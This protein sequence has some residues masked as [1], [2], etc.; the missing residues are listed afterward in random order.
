MPDGV[1]TFG[2]LKGQSLAGKGASYSAAG[3][4]VSN[5]QYFSR[6]IT[7]SNLLDE[8]NEPLDKD[9]ARSA[10]E[11]YGRD[12]AEYAGTVLNDVDV[13]QKSEAYILGRGF[14]DKSSVFIVFPVVTIQTS[15]QSNFK[16]SQ[17][18]LALTDQ[19]RSEG[20]FHKAQ[21]ILEN[22]EN[23]L[24]KRL[25]ENGYKPNYPREL[26]TLANIHLTHRYAGVKTSKSS[27]SV[28]STVVVPAGKKFDE[29]DFLYYKVREEQFSYRQGLIGQFE[30]SPKFAVLGSTYYHK[31]FSFEQ[32]RRIP[33]NSASPLSSDIDKNTKIKYGDTYGGSI[34]LNF[35]PNDAYLVYL[36]QSIEKK[37]KDSISGSKFSSE[38][39]NF[40]EQ[41][42]SQSLGLA[43]VGIAVDTIQ[44]FIA[45]KFPIP[46]NLNLQYSVSNSGANVFDNQAIAMNLMVFYK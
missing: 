17:S 41:N 25:D 30:L 11:V 31:R 18:L 36:G 4:S 44:S 28:D 8:I 15:F 34:Q 38:R 14:G 23:A 16:H 19:L 39:Y 12:G 27:L 22:S 3:K 37:V 29:D 35:A 9:L 45:N 33:Q 40:L 32:S 10:F 24:R 2:V 46:V 21:E 7:Y 6:D 13:A 1:W 5:Q 20:Q 43:Y 26:T 42:T